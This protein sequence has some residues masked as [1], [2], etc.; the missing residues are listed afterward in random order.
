[1]RILVIIP[2]YNEEEKLT[3]VI[4]EVRECQVEVD[5]VVINDCSSDG[6]QLAAEKEGVPVITLSV[7]LGIGGAVQTGFKYASL[8]GYDIAVQ[9]DAD[10]QHNPNQIDR[11]IKPILEDHVDM[12][13]G[14]RFLKKENNGTSHIMRLIGM[15]L[16]SK[17]TSRVVGLTI[18]DTTSGFRAVGKELIGYFSKNYPVD[19]PDSEAI[20]MIHKAGFTIVEVPVAINDRQG[21]KSS[22]NFGKSFFYPFK[23][24]ISILSVLLRSIKKIR[25]EKP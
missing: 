18:T 14:S 25:K 3:D 23:V 22:T 7:N 5:I 19:F 6:T 2:A 17:I 24:G 9:V 4:R 10:G 13:I 12:V 11:L 15:R 21:G 20:I 8:H 16:F 1:M